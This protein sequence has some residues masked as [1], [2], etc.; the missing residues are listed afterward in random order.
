L[1]DLLPK[2]PPQLVSSVLA[3]AVSH[4]TRLHALVFLSERPAGT[5][6]EIA[7]HIGLP[8]NNVSHHIKVLMDLGCVEIASI[9]QAHGGRVAQHLYRAT[10][11]AYLDE[12][13][14]DQLKSSEKLSFVATLMRL[15][16]EDFVQATLHGTLYDPDNNHLSRSPMNVDDEGWE[17]VI[18]ILDEAVEE[19]FKVQE[20]VASRGA[21]KETKTFPI[22]VEILQFRSPDKT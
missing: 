4:P 16:S 14:W 5:A 3:T 11:K 1:E 22:K 21:A 13:A 12:E 9:D 19:L 17:E 6:R 7:E 2:A 15:I 10:Q 20:E 18:A 8:T